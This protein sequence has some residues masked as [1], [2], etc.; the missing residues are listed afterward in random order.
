M[1]I[2]YSQSVFF[3]FFPLKELAALSWPHVNGTKNCHFENSA[4][5]SSLPQQKRQTE[6]K[7]RKQTGI[8]YQGKR[9][10]KSP[11]N[12]VDEAPQ[13][14]FQKQE[15]KLKIFKENNCRM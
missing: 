1:A 9:L 7:D 12:Y 5:Q 13:N 14:T 11:S 2:T 4:V 6:T 10:E 15:Q 3:F 8:C